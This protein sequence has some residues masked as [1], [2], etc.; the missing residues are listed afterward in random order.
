MIPPYIFSAVSDALLNGCLLGYGVIRD[1]H[2]YS[3]QS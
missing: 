1:A 2:I 3:F